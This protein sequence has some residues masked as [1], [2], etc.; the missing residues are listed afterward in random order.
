MIIKE[1]KKIEIRLNERRVPER[2][3][4][5]IKRLIFMSVSFEC[6]GLYEPYLD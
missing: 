2:I 4:D 3:V 1:I 6:Y 5:T